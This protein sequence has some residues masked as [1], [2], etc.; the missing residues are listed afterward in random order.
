MEHRPRTTDRPATMADIAQQL[1]ISRQLVSIVM[2]DAPGA[3]AETRRRVRE[4]AD[5]LGFAPH[6]GARTLRR[7]R[8][9]TFGVV[10]VPSHPAEHEIVQSLYP[11]AAA[12]GYDV[13]LSAVTGTRGV[14]PAV[15]ELLG[16]RC[17]AVLLIGSA[18]DPAELEDLSGRVQIPLVA[19]GTAAGGTGHD[20]VRSDGRAG[21]AAGVEHLVSLG[22]REIAFVDL[23]TMPA[24]ALRRAGYEQTMQRHE[25]GTDVVL[26]SGH[27][28]DDAYFE[29][30]GSEAAHTLLARDEPPTAVMVPNDGSAVTLLL[31]LARHGLQ[32]PRDISLVGYDDIPAARLSA[33]EL[34]TV[35]QDPE[36]MARAAVDAAVRRIDHPESDPLESIVD[37]S[38]VLRGSCAALRTDG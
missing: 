12:H 17:A 20:V 27:Y 29:E 11:L 3:S 32:V 14:Q 15:D 9:W 4:T 25:L 38:L 31:T 34:T 36:L 21:V 22:H 2:R 10:F 7:T 33:V 28:T 6:T 30:S 1:G 16:H 18:L 24:A 37:T 5:E 23:A 8:S 26:A 13:V 19:V 35:R